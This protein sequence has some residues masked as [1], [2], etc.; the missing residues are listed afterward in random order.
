MPKMAHDEPGWK[1]C[2]FS[3]EGFMANKTA[4]RFIALLM[5][6]LTMAAVLAGCAAPQS[7]G[8]PQTTP[9]V[10][11]V[12]IV[13]PADTPVAAQSAAST[14]T[15]FSAGIPKYIF[16]FIGD[17]MSF[18]QVQAAQA[19]QGSVAGE[20]EPALLNFTRFPVVGTVTTYDATSY[21]PDSASAGT[22]IA[23]GVKTRRGVLGL[24]ADKTTAVQ[25]IAELLKADGKRVGIISSVSLNNA[26]P[27][28]FYAHAGSRSGYDEIVAQMAQSGFDYF[29]GGGLYGI[30]RSNG[31]SADALFEQNGYAIADTRDE[32][33][34]L[35]GASGR[36]YAIS[37]ALANSATMPFALDAEEGS[38]S[39]AD[40]VRIGIGVM[41]GEDG[42]FMMCEGGKIDLACHAHD[43]AAVIGEVLALE[44][45]VQVA[46]DF[47][48][49]HPDET[50]VLVTADHETGG[51]ALGYTMTEYDTSFELLQS[52]RVSYSA[53]S[54]MLA[55]MQDANPDLA[56][57]DVLPVIKEYFG[58]IAPGKGSGA[59]VMTDGEYVRLK[60]A[61]AEAMKPAGERSDTV[62]AKLLY[63]GYN[64]LTVTLTQILAGKAGIGWTT[65]YH[66][67]A[68]VPVYAYGVGAELF[69][70]SYD[71]TDI[72]DKLVEI[73]GL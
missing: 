30:D 34:A 27:A 70:G 20:I 1:I 66:T 4:F 47:A 32:I 23:C 3:G 71:N 44:D 62:E 15:A 17:G 7:T 19:Y 2:A 55:D 67:G 13:K 11:T 6:A 64:P 63:G 24:E 46:V 31:R 18:A 48:A 28:A 53:F 35:G 25:S 69:S 43:A 14:A 26:T 50:L 21:I 61:F 54:A 38:L 59:Y 36:V 40:F 52:Q 16:L 5:C 57:G 65:W 45:A 33:E 58:L 49:Q 73:C 60:A 51:M 42:F 22:A 12:V 72:F 68:L 39:L 8:T 56:L 41:E 37:P 10:P 9:P 29:G